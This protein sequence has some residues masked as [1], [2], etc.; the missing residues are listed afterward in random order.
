M[1]SVGA[2]LLWRASDRYARVAATRYEALRRPT[3][4]AAD[5]RWLS[6]RADAAIRDVV[7]PLDAHQ[8]SAAATG[9]QVPGSRSALANTAFAVSRGTAPI[10]ARNPNGSASSPP[11]LVA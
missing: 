10:I 1:N 6:A 5:T 4:V 9:L 11:M 8:G 2:S 7:S 3:G